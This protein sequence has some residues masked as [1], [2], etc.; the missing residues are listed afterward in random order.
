MASVPADAAVIIVAAILTVEVVPRVWQNHCLPRG[1]IETRRLSPRNILP[2]ELPLSIE[3]DVYTS[4]GQRR[5]DYYRQVQH[6]ENDESPK[7]HVVA[8]I[9]SEVKSAFLF[10]GRQEQVA[11]L[12]DE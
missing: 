9:L 12:E 2:D 11:A 8:S 1:I 7:F 10:P 5:A 3:A 6:H 4:R